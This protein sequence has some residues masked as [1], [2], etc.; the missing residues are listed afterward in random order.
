MPDLCEERIQFLADHFEEMYHRYNRPEFIDPDPVGVVRSYPDL[1]DREVAAVVSSCLAYGRAAGIVKSARAILDPM[2]PSPH[3][4]L[5]GSSPLEIR[6]ICQNFRHRFTDCND[7]YELLLSIR[8]ILFEW[9]SIEALFASGLGKDEKVTGGLRK[10]YRSLQKNSGKRKN[11][12]LPNVSRGSACKRYNLMIKWMVRNDGIDPGGWRCL[13][14]ASLI[15]PLDTHMIR[16]CQELGLVTR[17][18][19]DMVTANQAT[20]SFR[21]I[22]PQ[23][24]TKYDFTLTRFGIRPDLKMSDLLG[25]CGHS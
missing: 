15:L 10:L 22:A 24:P 14:P 12:L 18:T 3:G 9:G 1:P 19:P 16:I 17:K 8:D 2:G 23:D 5:T 13:S 7:I 11:S 20:R 6:M 4:F 25:Q 21:L